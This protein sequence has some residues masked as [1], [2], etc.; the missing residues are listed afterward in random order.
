MKPIFF[1]CGFGLLLLS[2]A[3]R[4]SETPQAAQPPQPPAINYEEEKAA[5]LK[6]I[7]GESEAFWNK[8]YEKFAS[9]WVHEPYI[10][11]M[12]WWQAGGVTVVSGW[13]E[14]S[15]RTKAHMEESPEANAT[16]NNV[17]RENINL[18]IY[19][20]VAWLTFDQYGEDTGDSLMDMPG[21][22]RETRILEKHNGEWRIVYVGWLLEGAGKE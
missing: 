9:Y 21:L 16:A 20:D 13:E 10:R 11:T 6:V 15:A 4:H 17:R 8:D 3:C 18:R 12:G 19:Q 7:D 22:S 5:I 2:Y 14:R 1:T